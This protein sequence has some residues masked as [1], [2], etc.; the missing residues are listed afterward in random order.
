MDIKTVAAS[1]NGTKSLDTRSQERAS[2]DQNVSLN[3]ASKA[4]NDQVTLTDVS[5]KL[6]GL[7]DNTATLE[8]RQAKI[9]QIKAA[10]SAG[11]YPINPEKIA[12]KLI[13]TEQLFARLN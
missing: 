10:I 3:P 7:T 12:S 13:E 2:Q 1:L 11:E 8:D 6:S 4:G 9:D 5:Q